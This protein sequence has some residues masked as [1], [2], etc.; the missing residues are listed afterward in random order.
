MDAPLLVLLS[1]AGAV[2]AWTLAAILILR[3]E[4]RRQPALTRLALY[5]F[6]TG[7]LLGLFTLL[8]FNWMA[9]STWVRVA[10]DS[11]G[12]LIG[13]LFLDHIRS[14]VGR[15]RSGVASYSPVMLYFLAVLIFREA[16]IQQ[17]TIG[18]LAALLAISRGF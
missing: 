10:H 4:L 6:S 14:A 18:H 11:V 12:V 13:A 1:F 2:N 16:F 8:Y 17:V 9:L 3:P 5:L 7:F 15:G